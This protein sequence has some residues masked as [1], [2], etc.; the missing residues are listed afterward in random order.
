M[1]RESAIRCLRRCAR[2]FR[3][4]SAQSAVPQADRSLGMHSRRNVSRKLQGLL[5][6][7]EPRCL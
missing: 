2:V 3:C 6:L 7:H 5:G 1:A 4:R